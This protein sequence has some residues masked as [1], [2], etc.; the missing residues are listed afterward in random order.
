MTNQQGLLEWA[1]QGNLEAIASLL[2]LQMK[3]EGITV[4]AGMNN[5]SLQI[6][7]E[8]N[9]VPNPEKSVAFVSKELG[10]LQSEVIYKVNVYGRKTGDDIPAWHQELELEPQTLPNWVDVGNTSSSQPRQIVSHEQQVLENCPQCGKKLPPPLK[11]TGRQICT[12][13]GW[14]K[15]SIKNASKTSSK[16]STS[17]F[18]IKNM[19]GVILSFSVES[20]QGIISGDDGNKY[21]FSSS[22]WK[23]TKE[24]PRRGLRVDFETED[25]KAIEIY[26]A[27]EEVRTS[28]EKGIG[29]RE[30]SS[31]S[32]TA[33]S[34]LFVA[35]ELQK[36]LELKEKGVLSYEEF[37]LRIYYISLI[38]QETG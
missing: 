3:V 10:S 13:C 12:S 31:A 6:M 20:D 26:S 11:S 4:K 28:A 16:P 2:T 34:N 27:L 38:L 30:N 19:K 29:W 24:F 33:T 32:S 35:D 21:N 9:E 18:N 14:A 37:E 1:K 5:G 8:A 7:L 22:N 36:L 23:D 17:S 25:K 15:K